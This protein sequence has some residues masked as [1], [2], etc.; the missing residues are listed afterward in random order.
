[1]RAHSRAIILV[2]AALLCSMARA[3]DG[4]PL[5]TP[6]DQDRSVSA[7]VTASGDTTSDGASL[8]YARVSQM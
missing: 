4:T 3:D 5:L 7:H 1:M 2:A 8:P 6:I